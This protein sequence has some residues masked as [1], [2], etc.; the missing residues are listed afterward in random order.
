MALEIR[1]IEIVPHPM[2]REVRMFGKFAFGS[3][4]I[5]F[6]SKPTRGLKYANG[7]S[8]PRIASEKPKGKL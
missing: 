8:F 7:S 1:S 6:G 2:G 5:S 4:K 3:E